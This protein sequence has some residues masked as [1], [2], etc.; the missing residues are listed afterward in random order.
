MSPH[1]AL[2]SPSTDALQPTDFSLTS[3]PT[4]STQLPNP[5]TMD[6]FPSISLRCDPADEIAIVVAAEQWDDVLT[7]PPYTPH[8]TSPPG[9]ELTAAQAFDF[10]DLPPIPIQREKTYKCSQPSR[11]CHICGRK[12][13]NIRVAACGRIMGNHCRKVVC[14]RCVEKHGW[15]DAPIH[16]IPT[17]S[18]SCPHCRGGCPPKAQCNTY[19]RTNFKRHL[20][21]LRRRQ[22]RLRK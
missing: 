7:S 18:W 8:Q 16:G 4:F 5:F 15:A 13:V 19:G 21:L 11:F 6:L 17:P 10:R 2:T 12:A 9:W 3:N 22:Y 14:E 1:L 20:A